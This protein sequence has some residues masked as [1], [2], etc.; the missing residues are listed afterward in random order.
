MDKKIIYINGR[1]LTH[2]M[3]GIPRFAY[4]MCRAMYRNRMNIMVVAPKILEELND[5]PFPVTYYG[6][7]KSHA[8]EQWD[9]YCFMRKKSGALLISFSGLGPICYK[10]H[11]PTIHDLSFWENP[12]WFSFSY[13]LFYRIFTPWIAR[14]AQRVI[15]VSR[16]SQKEIAKDLEISVE[17]IFVVPNAVAPQLQSDAKTNEISRAQSSEKYILMVASR[18][19][20]KNV[21]LAV[22]AFLSLHLDDIKLY[23]IGDEGSVF[24]NT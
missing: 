12:Q 15:T 6:K 14:K 16:F 21:A 20:R 2:K 4:E 23:L 11:I 1:F 3:T 7:K 9:L 13:N 19:P 5:F 22:E 8:W 24:K 17:K 10:P 18:D